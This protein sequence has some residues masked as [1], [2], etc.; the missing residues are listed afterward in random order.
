MQILP[1]TF[2]PFWHKHHP[3]FGPYT[4]C[5]STPCTCSYRTIISTAIPAPVVVLVSPCQHPAMQ[6][7]PSSTCNGID[8]ATQTSIVSEESD[9]STTTSSILSDPTLPQHAHD[10]TPTETAER[11]SKCVFP[12]L[13]SKL[14]SKIQRSRLVNRTIRNN[15]AKFEDCDKYLN[16]LKTMEKELEAEKEK[17][18]ELAALLRQAA[19][20]LTASVGDWEKMMREHLE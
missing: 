11:F 15:L 19:K 2:H 14:N 1:H 10:D 12:V 8:E 18:S 6:P 4:F 5:P 13:Q 20:K 16:T 7:S 3:T 9:T 17:T